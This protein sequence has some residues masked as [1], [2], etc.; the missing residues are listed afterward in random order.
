MTKLYSHPAK[1]LQ[2]HLDEVSKA[3]HIIASYHSRTDTFQKKLDELVRLHDF[4]KGTSFFQEFITFKPN[5]EQWTGRKENKAHTLLGLFAATKIKEAYLFSNEWL[6]QIGTSIL[7]H[8]SSLPSRED[9]D[10]R[11]QCNAKVLIIQLKELALVEL[12]KLTGFQFDQTLLSNT[13][14]T[15]FDVMDNWDELFNWLDSLTLENAIEQRLNTQKLF[16]I[17]LEADKSFLALSK[18]AQERYK[19]RKF[20]SIESNIVD[21]YLQNKPSSP[22]NAL[23]TQARCD[24]LTTLSKSSHKSMFTL[25]LPTGLGKTLTAASLAFQLREEKKRQVIIV[26]P[27]LAIIDQTA[28]EYSKVLDSPTEETLMQSH[29]LSARDYLELED[30]DAE[31]FLDTW[32]SDIIITTFDQVL[33]ALLSSKAK[34]QMRFHHLC[35]A[36]IIFDEIQA[37]PTH[38]WSIT[39][40]ALNEL[41]KSFGSTIIAMSATQPGF[42]SKSQEL[43]PNFQEFFQHFGRYKIVLKHQ[44]DMPLTDF[45]EM[46]IERLHSLRKKRVLI[47]LNTRASARFVFDKLNKLLEDRKI[48]DYPVYLLSADVTPV[49]RLEIIERLK[50]YKSKPCLVISTQVVEAGVDI[51]MDLVMRDFAPLDSLIQ[52]AGRCNRNNLNPRCDVEIYSLTTDSHKRYSS[53]VYRKID[54]SPDISLQE[55]RKVLEGR[56]YVLEEDVFNLCESYFS[57]IRQLDDLGQIHTK[58]WAY[59]KKHLDVSKLLRGEQ[60]NQYQFIVAER[61]KEGNLEKA[62]KKALKIDDRWKKRRALRKLASR[63]ASVSVSVWGK[64]N[65]D[66]NTVAYSVGGFW[67]VH[68]GLYSTKRGLD[69]DNSIFI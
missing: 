1:L 51:D 6:L 59:F 3:T 39:Q 21:I 19:S 53:M 30:Q 38:L 2:E 61:D 60:D 31:F 16:S 14:E 23:R 48:D 63:L 67:F 36:V 68:D 52:I 62:V 20:T 15:I 44:S 50:K 18:E 47:T 57:A 46:V 32:Q 29:S 12:E 11:L 9:I 54:G 35:D 27:F 17:L 42:I 55:T 5:P 69:I 13:E 64:P 24:A 26:L 25:T 41:N 49:D 4:G 34:H 40:Y 65:F 43:I 45:S 37:L 10:K 58:N 8:H 22:V 28:K 7:G 66:P 33:L 56:H